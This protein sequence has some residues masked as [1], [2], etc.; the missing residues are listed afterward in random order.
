MRNSS[1]CM[2]VKPLGPSQTLPLPLT[3]FACRQNLPSGKMASLRKIVIKEE[4]S[5]LSSSRVVEIEVNDEAFADRLRNLN[6]STIHWSDLADNW[7]RHDFLEFAQKCSGPDTQ[8]FFLLRDWN[9][10]LF[11]SQ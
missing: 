9:E 10:H 6:P 1:K 11:G 8:H 5:S 7:N 3:T 2:A 4:T